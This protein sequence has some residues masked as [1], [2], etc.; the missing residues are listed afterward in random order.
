MAGKVVY[1][2]TWIRISREELLQRLK[3]Q[4]TEKRYKHSLRVEETALSMAKELKA[5]MEKV[6]IAALLHDYAKDMDED[7]MLKL[8]EAY[9]PEGHLRDSNDAVWHG[10]AAAQ[11]AREELGITDTA[12]L[13]A[14]AFHTVGNADMDLLAKIVFVADFIEPGRSFDGVDKARK[15]AKKNI[16]EAV[17]YKL[18]SSIIHTIESR[19]RLFPH[20]VY[21]YNQW[22]HKT[23]A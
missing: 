11:I 7:R 3:A 22:I 23:N 10:F 1:Q 20:S 16:D 17:I 2:G 18:G 21:V 9:W 8:A 4:V 6:S 15:L 13:S 5:D 14:V 19:E 12:I